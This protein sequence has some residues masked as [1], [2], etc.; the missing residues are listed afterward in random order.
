MAGER[1]GAQVCSCTA[2]LAPTLAP[3]PL[4]ATPGLM[5]GARAA[6][7]GAGGG[8]GLTVAGGLNEV[9]YPGDPWAQR[10]IYRLT[11]G[12]GTVPTPL[13]G[14]SLSPQHGGLGQGLVPGRQPGEG[15]EG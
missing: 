12:L 6:L 9:A 1:E 11:L 2:K 5:L 8:P 14:P 13:S 15:L 4:L 10:A 7:T 3:H